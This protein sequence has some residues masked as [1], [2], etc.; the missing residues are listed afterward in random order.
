MNGPARVSPR[1]RMCFALFAIVGLIGVTGTPASAADPDLSSAWDSSQLNVVGVVP[2]PGTPLTGDI[3]FFFDGRIDEAMAKSGAASVPF[4]AEPNLPGK[5]HIGPSFIRLE[6]PA[7]PNNA[8][9]GQR[10]PAVPQVF[11]VK[12]N[13][14]IASADGRRINPKQIDWVFAPF[15]FK[16]EQIWVV[17]E[18]PG[19]TVLGIRFPEPP[20][21]RS[22]GML[23]PGAPSA[24]P[25]EGHIKVQQQSDG[26]AVPFDVRRGQEPNTILVTIH[27]LKPVPL[28]LVVTKGLKDIYGIL[29]TAEDSEFLY[30][31]ENALKV[32]KVQ[33]GDYKKDEQ[34]IAFEFSDVVKLADLKTHLAIKNAADNT[35]LPF[36]VRGEGDSPAAVVAIHLPQPAGAR[37]AVRISPGMPGGNDTTLKQPY[38]TELKRVVAPLQAETQLSQWEEGLALTVKLSRPVALKDL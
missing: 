3:V 26:A 17:E 34:T 5:F 19:E 6:R 9:A 27:T 16:V 10:P 31:R 2:L 37:V 13:E 22:A 30:S 1:G 25:A 15:V 20:N 18:K 23:F 11:R 8:A 7:V 32:N 12:L 4:T 21:P 36:E 38:A 14:S 33:W 35:D 28:R 24:Q 29:E